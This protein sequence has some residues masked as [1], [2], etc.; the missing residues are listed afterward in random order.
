MTS[1]SF[2]DKTALVT[3]ANSGL[4]FEAAAQLAEA[5][6]GRIILACRSLE[7]AEGAR[8]ALVERVDSDPFATLAIDVA[9]IASSKAA[10][11]ELIERGH[12]IDALL[13]N[14][15]VVPGDDM[16]K[17]SDGLEVAFAASLIGHHLLT[18]ELLQADLLDGARVVLVGSEAANDELPAMM[19]MKLYD[20]ASGTPA[21]FGTDLHEAMITFARGEKPEQYVGTRYYSTTK[22]FS[23]WWS[24][25]MAHR[26][27][28]KTTFY[29]VSPGSNM[30]TNAAR[31]ATGFK[32]ILFTVV[33]PAIGPFIGWDQPVHLGAKRYVDVLNDRG[34]D[35]KSGKTYTS[36]PKK[37]IGALH[38]VTVP[39][40]LDTR[41]QDVAFAVLGELAGVADAPVREV[42]RAQ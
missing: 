28:D 7:K 19:G 15:G 17:T 13:L 11:A 26:F 23:A 3:G 38:E 12:P 36:A 14:A 29:T 4:G 10:A 6:Y 27:G 2:T 32:R 1:S 21:E 39:H 5:G 31:H 8:E 22:A 41:R 35:F 30:S 34:A 42:S 33:M 20:F 37:M 24:A 16:K 18:L 9:D 25:A 40:L